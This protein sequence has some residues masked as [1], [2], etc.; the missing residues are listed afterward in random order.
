MPQGVAMCASGGQQAEQLAGPWYDCNYSVLLVSIA[1]STLPM[2]AVFCSG[3]AGVFVW[4]TWGVGR[5]GEVNRGGNYM[6]G[7]CYDHA[8]YM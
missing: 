4:M 1:S 6:S 2:R 3:A 5:T 8:I 7:I